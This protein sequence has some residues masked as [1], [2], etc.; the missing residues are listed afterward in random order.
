MAEE[1]RVQEQAWVR[2]DGAEGEGGGQLLRTSLTLSM[3]TGTP[4]EMVNIRAK[5]PNPGLQAQ[6]LQAILAA[7]AICGA[8]VEGAAKGALAVRFRPGRPRSGQYRFDIGT[9]G[10]TS[11]LL[12]TLYLPL[13]ACAQ[14]S[15]VRLIGGTHV[16]WSPTFNHLAEAWLPCLRAMG[17]TL[18][19][20]LVRAGFYPEGGGEIVAHLEPATAI[21]PLRLES[22][23][24]LQEVRI[25]S[26]HANLRDEV[27]SRQARTA[28]RLLEAAG[29]HP[30]VEQARLPAR[31]RGTVCAIA[32]VFEGA[33]VCYTALGERGKP[34][35]RVA[36]EACR[37][38]LAFLRTAA[39][40]DEYLAD[41]LVLP[42][43]LAGGPS[44]FRTPR[45]TQHLLTNI[46]TV[47]RFVPIEVRLVGAL[48]EPGDV[49]IVP[50]VPA[51]FGSA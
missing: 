48:G 6:H 1:V 22:R 7:Q 24:D 25:Y 13:H 38:F 43:A 8:A 36:E 42:L 14:P 26:A 5:R 19:L 34:A 28:Q 17:L 30:V 2:I 12:H 21:Q 3:V 51:P 47:R 49:E 41:Q 50:T 10:A 45:I 46:A 37:A 16:A 4:F 9:A 27:A 18:T 44:R 29:L 40:V 23:G 32:G 33:R 35:E 20:T 39:T 11:L 31:S 15:T